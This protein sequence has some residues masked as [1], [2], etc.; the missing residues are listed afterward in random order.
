MKAGDDETGDVRN[1]HHQIGADGLGDLLKF[2][3]I[4]DSRVGAGPDDNHPRPAF[5]GR[6]AHGFIINPL[7]RTVHTIEIGAVENP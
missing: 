4:E 2:R 5:L 6:L 3:K 1:I 7:A